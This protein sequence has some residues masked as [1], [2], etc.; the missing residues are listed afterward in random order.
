MVQANESDAPPL[1][2]KQGYSNSGFSAAVFAR[3]AIELLISIRASR[4]FKCTYRFIPEGWAHAYRGFRCAWIRLPPMRLSNLESSTQACTPYAKCTRQSPL[5]NLL[6]L[7]V[8]MAR[9]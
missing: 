1:A 2:G 6:V 9:L 4:D 5:G 7:R 3:R 8:S